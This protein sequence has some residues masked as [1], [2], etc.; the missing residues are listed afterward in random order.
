M[1][2][3]TGDYS[4]LYRRGKLTLPPG[5]LVPT[6]V[7]PFRVNS[8][9]PLEEGVEAGVR[10]IHLHK[11]GGHIH[12]RAEHFKQWLREVY[13]DKVTSNPTRPEQWKNTLYITQLVW[14]YGETLREIVWT[15]LVLTPKGNTDTRGIGLLESLWKVVEVIIDTCLRASVRL[16]N[17]LHGLRAGRGTGTNTLELN[18]AKELVS[19]DQ[20]PPFLVFL[21]L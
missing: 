1:V 16:Q 13:L 17:V 18:L 2:K 14:Q 15:I 7:T 20:D 10:R 6:H 21:D 9:V 8:D 11:L 5:R 19:V 4:A 12:L 3:V